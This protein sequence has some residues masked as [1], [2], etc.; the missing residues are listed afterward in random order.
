MIRFC[1]FLKNEIF[2]IFRS[3]SF[4]VVTALLILLAV[5]DG[6]LSIKTYQDNLE[7]SLN[8]YIVD[9]DGIFNNYPWLQNYTLFNSWLG[10][11]PNGVLPEIFFFLLPVFCV[12]PFSHSYLTEERIG[13]SKIM[14]VKLGKFKYFL[15]KYISAFVS[16]FITAAIPLA[17]SLTFTACFIPAYRPDVTL[18]YTGMDMRQILGNLYFANP[19][20]FCFATIMLSGIFAGIWSTIPV[21]VSLFTK[22]IFAALFAPYL[23]LL[24]IIFSVQRALAY[25][26][27]AAT[28]ILDYVRPTGYSGNE[29]WWIF[30]LELVLLTVPTLLFIL[31]KGGKRDVL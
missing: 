27:F 10:G 22:N 14:I 31:I 8:S 20:F 16:G 11:K 15:G 24:F 2:R 25:H 19:L 23:A 3:P 18:I 6:I 26:S 30:L 29:Y 5:L 7:M 1:R 17:F 13:Y 12:I 9:E 28:S 21:A 4:I